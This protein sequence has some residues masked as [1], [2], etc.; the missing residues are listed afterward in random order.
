MSI[1]IDE[2]VQAPGKQGVRVSNPVENDQGNLGV[3]QLV[4]CLPS[5]HKAL[6]AIPS[7]GGKK[8]SKEEVTSKMA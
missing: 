8:A 1:T 3:I 6:C 7:N 5:M 4:E 2:K